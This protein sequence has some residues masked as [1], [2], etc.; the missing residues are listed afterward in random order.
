M[1]DV[2]QFD[3]LDKKAIQIKDNTARLNISRLQTTVSNNKREVDESFA[4]METAISNLE[5]KLLKLPNKI[6]CT[7][8]IIIGDSYTEGGQPDGTFVKSWATWLIESLKCSNSYILGKSGMGYARQSVKEK[9]NALETWIAHRNEITWKNECTAIFIMLGLN[10][11]NQTATAI[12][13]AVQSFLTQL[14]TDCPN[15]YIVCMFNPDYGFVDCDL[16][17]VIS[18]AVM[19]RSAIWWSIEDSMIA[20]PTWYA[21]DNTHPNTTGQWIL[22]KIIMSYIKG[23]AFENNWSLYYDTPNQFGFTYK[24]NGKGRNICMKIKGSLN[25]SNKQKVIFIPVNIGHGAKLPYLIPV[26]KSD[27]TVLHLLFNSTDSTNL[28]IINTAGATGSIECSF[29][30]DGYAVWGQGNLPTE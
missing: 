24:M 9:K 28:V 3:V 4:E 16:I 6:D 12:T 17:R 25:G 18:D 10:D 30:F 15:A 14:R 26:S 29:N 8:T 27:G 19:E 13:S 23:S 21:S 22:S 7:N 5:S 20:H 1:S 2:K 11:N